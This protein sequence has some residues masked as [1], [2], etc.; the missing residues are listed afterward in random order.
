MLGQSMLAAG[1]TMALVVAMRTTLD[2][3]LRPWGV[4]G[5]ALAVV[6]LGLGWFW[7]WPQ[8]QGGM[9]GAS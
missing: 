1:P 3:L 8:A 5:L 4:A 6:E 2:P 7:L 9:A